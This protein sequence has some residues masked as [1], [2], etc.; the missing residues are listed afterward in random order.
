[1]QSLRVLSPR[2]VVAALALVATPTTYAVDRMQLQACAGLPGKEQRLA[3]FEALAAQDRGEPA[4]A[5]S[6]G[7]VPPAN[8][9]GGQARSSP[10]QEPAAAEGPSARGGSW[11]SRHWELDAADKRAPLAFR[12]HRDNYVLFANVSSS[13][14][15]APFRPFAPSL[16]FDHTEVGF[17]LGFKMKLAPAVL[18][19]PVDLWFGYTQQTFW[20]AYNK[21]ASNPIRE[22][23]Y[24][25]EL[26]AVAPVDFTILG[27]RA[28]L[29]NIG[30]AHQS[31]G[32][33]STL[34]RS[35]NRVYAQLGLERGD[36]TVLLRAWQ[37]IGNLADNPDIIDWYG[38]GDLLATYRW[39]EHEFS[40]LLRR[41]WRTERG[42]VQAS[43]AFPLAGTLKGYV[44]LFSGYGDSLI[45]YNVRQQTF[46]V[47]VL[48]GF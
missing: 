42:A 23:N 18:D 37:P 30:I 1:M 15:V 32:Q 31:N 9:E 17:Q 5:G 26:M 8:R 34:S 39:H 40:A 16:R 33:P 36:F 19:S 3:C 25:P 4:A 35:W 46:G 44:Q 27:W 24:Q 21:R 41:N 13:P 14:N 47:G 6:P 45:N 38:H 11:L 12:T 10:E 7:V 22:T 48:V 28:R 29:L 20:Q 43:W 2:V